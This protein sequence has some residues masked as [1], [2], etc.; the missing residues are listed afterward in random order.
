M[1]Y[2]S[3]SYDQNSPAVQ[4]DLLEIQLK[5]IHVV[6]SHNQVYFL[7]AGPYNK[8]HSIWGPYWGAPSLEKLPY[9]F[10]MSHLVL[11]NSD[12]TTMA[13]EGVEQ[14]SGFGLGFRGKGFRV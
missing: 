2:S 7:G 12:L 10:L 4:I 3:P 9:R 6:V 11:C 14:P 13:F 5:T 8:D 1:R